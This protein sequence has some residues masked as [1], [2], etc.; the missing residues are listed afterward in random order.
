MVKFKQKVYTQ[1]DQTDR[2]KQMKDSDIL[3]EKKRSNTSMN[4][5]TT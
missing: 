2:L 1:W 4:M 5:Q 3:S